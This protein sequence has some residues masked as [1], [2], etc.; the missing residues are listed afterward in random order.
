MSANGYWEDYTVCDYETVTVQTPY[1]ACSYSGW[2]HG[3]GGSISSTAFR[4]YNGHISCPLSEYKNVHERVWLGS[5][6]VDVWFDGNLPL[7]NQSHLYNT[8]TE[9]RVVEGS[10]RTER[11]WIE[12][13]D[14]C[15]IP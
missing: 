1:T 13:C 7:T 15:P 14:T 12:L 3:N 4:T 10:C 6:F 2:L 5:E 9:Q 11:V 8:T